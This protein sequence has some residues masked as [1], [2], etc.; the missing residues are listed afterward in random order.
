M[1]EKNKKDLKLLIEENKAALARLYPKEKLRLILFCENTNSSDAKLLKA[2]AHLLYGES[3][4]IMVNHLPENTH[5]PK[6]ILPDS[7]LKAK[8]RSAKRI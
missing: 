6:N 5:G 7:H 8:E 2:I 3:L 4:E 1:I